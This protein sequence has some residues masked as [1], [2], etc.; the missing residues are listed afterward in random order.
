[1]YSPKE[2]ILA[3]TDKTSEVRVLTAEKAFKEKGIESKVSY[4]I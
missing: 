4:T 2:Y 3:A 1:M